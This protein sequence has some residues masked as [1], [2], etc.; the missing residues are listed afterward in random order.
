MNTQQKR[1]T[2]NNPSN[3]MNDVVCIH[4]SLKLKLFIIFLDRPLEQKITEKPYILR[5]IWGSAQSALFGRQ[6]L[7]VH[8]CCRTFCHLFRILV[9]NPEYRWPDICKL[10]NRL[11]LHILFE[12]MDTRSSY[13]DLGSQNESNIEKVN[14]TLY[15][16]VTDKAKIHSLKFTFYLK[17]ERFSVNV[18]KGRKQNLIS[19]TSQ[20]TLGFHTKLNSENYLEQHTLVKGTLGKIFQLYGTSWGFIHRFKGLTTLYTAAQLKQT[21]TNS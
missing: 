20:P 14:C 16:A 5:G 9:D 8:T 12:E 6:P 13:M 10:A 2:V 3:I 19:M 17:Y 15:V 18:R 11:L 21:A 7:P 1:S 4:H